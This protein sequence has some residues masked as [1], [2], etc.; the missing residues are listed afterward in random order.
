MNDSSAPQG[1]STILSNDVGFVAQ[2]VGTL[3]P[4]T[5]TLTSSPTSYTMS[6]TITITGGT[7]YTIG[8]IGA[9][10]GTVT[11]NNISAAEYNWKSPEEFVDAFPDF[12]RIEKMCK[13][14]PGLAIAFDK[15]KTTYNL[16]KD[17][18]DNPKDK[19]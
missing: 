11:F 3:L 1:Y 4:D 2:E 10:A 9:G 14:Y 6:D 16:V 17:D 13:E 12:N 18:Y 5:I 15:F 8:A 7:G 19:K